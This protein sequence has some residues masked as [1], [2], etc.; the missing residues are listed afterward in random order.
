MIISLG[1]FFNFFKVL[2]FWVVRGVKGQK[3]SQNDKKMS[4]MLHISGTIHMIVI[5]GTQV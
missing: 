4:V 3:N 5:Y 2:I 1:V